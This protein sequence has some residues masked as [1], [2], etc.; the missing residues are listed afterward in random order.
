MGD[1]VQGEVAR[2][3]P[4]KG[5][6]F[7]TP[8]SG[9]EDVFV[10]VNDLLDDKQLVVPGA[11]VEFVVESGER[12]LKAT[13]I[14]VVSSPRRTESAPID[15]SLTASGFNSLSATEVHGDAFSMRTENHDDDDD[16]LV[17]S[18]R[19]MREHLTE[20][21]LN[22]SPPLTST[23][24]IAVRRAITDFAMSFGWIE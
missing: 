16:I 9:G 15:S 22:V 6:G 1:V 14:H 10:H 18:Q 17:L 2:F 19:E 13:S 12:G 4:V 23:Q 11:T 7:I 24:V 8:R 20:T 3:D 21:L 5:Y